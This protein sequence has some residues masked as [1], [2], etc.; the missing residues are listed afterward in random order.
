MAS[1]SS[2]F[3]V[4]DSK[5]VN[6]LSMERRQPPQRLKDFLTEDSIPSSTFRR[7][8]CGS[9]IK[10][11][12]NV[13]LNTNYV[14]EAPSKLLRSRSK[15][16]ATTISAIHKASGIVIK[17]VKFLP[18]TS[19]SILHTSI[20]RRLTKR[21]PQDNNNVPEIGVSVTVKDILRWRS[22]RD[23]VEEGPPPLDFSS[24]PLHC[25]TATTTT[26]SSS[27]TATTSKSSS[28][29]DSDFAEYLQSW[30]G[31]SDEF[32]GEDNGEVGKEFLPDGGAGDSCGVATRGTAVDYKI[33]Q[34]LDKKE[35]HSPVSVLDSPFQEDEELCS[36]FHQ[37]L[38]NMERR[39][40]MLM[41]M[42]EDFESA[43]KLEPVDIEKQFSNEANSG[44]ED[45]DEEEE[46]QQQR[47][48][49]ATVMCEEYEGY[50]EWEVESKREAY[51]KDMERGVKWNKF[52]EEQEELILKMES[53]VLSNLVDDLLVDLF[54][55]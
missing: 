54:Y 50:F 53:E 34:P 33:D 36:S 12:L 17:A 27:T 18:F 51:I 19:P 1:L 26:G 39:T 21:N 47:N 48:D 28:W 6:P 46:Q 7:T 25:T 31:V 42:I 10:T 5:H 13:D 22:F 55:G 20:S 32:S 23:L 4:T 35:Q 30:H 9:T 14:D 2:P 37:S 45:N 40:C 8:P 16:A 29:C 49:V 11:L 52:E 41:Q 43:A 38:A 24:S 44:F 3:W 15:A